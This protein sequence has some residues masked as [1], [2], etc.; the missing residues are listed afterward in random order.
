MKKCKTI[1]IDSSSKKTGYAVWENGK[2]IRSGLINKENISDMSERL[3]AMMKELTLLFESEKPDI[4]F[5]EEMNVSRNIDTGRHLI[6]LQGAIQYWCQVVS[7]AWFSTVEPTKWRANVELKPKSRKRDDLKKAAVEYVKTHYNKE[8]NDDEAE[9]ICLG[10][11]MMN[12][13]RKQ[14]TL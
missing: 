3:P 14:T 10:E 2:F 6:R 7:D 13:Y 8:V 9:A 4:I 1:S 12:M 11:G 5:V